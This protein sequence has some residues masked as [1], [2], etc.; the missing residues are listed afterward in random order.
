MRVSGCGGFGSVPGVEVLEV[1]GFI[2]N[3][4]GRKSEHSLSYIALLSAKR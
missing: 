4:Y 2:N 3:L 1:L